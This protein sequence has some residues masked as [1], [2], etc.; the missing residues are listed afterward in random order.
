M[1]A[2]HATSGNSYEKSCMTWIPDSASDKQF[3]SATEYFH[4]TPKKK[5]K[6]QSTL[7]KKRTE[8]KHRLDFFYQIKRCITSMYE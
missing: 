1:T 7:S 5:R 4:W 8:R 6:T 3:Q 2:F